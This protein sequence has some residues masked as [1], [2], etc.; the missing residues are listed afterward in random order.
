MNWLNK[1]M[2]ISAL[3]LALPAFA[4]DTPAKLYRSPK[5][6][7]CENYAKYLQANGYDVQIINTNDLSSI[8]RE[9]HVPERLEG[10]HTTLINGY[11]FE[12]HVPVESIDRVLQE[13]PTIRGLSVPG[14]PAGSPGMTGVRQ[15]PLE[16]YYLMDSAKP[17][18]YETH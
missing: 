4:G 5:C 2:L 14:M 10:C 7:C 11:V 3:T 6:G 1:A 16:V 13:H 15:G 12:G 9:H 17:Q 18:V 8:K